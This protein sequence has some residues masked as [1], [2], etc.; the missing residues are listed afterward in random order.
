VLWKTEKL[1]I[2][3]KKKLSTEPAQEPEM[4]LLGTHLKEMES[5][6]SKVPYTPVTI[7]TLFT[8]AELGNRPR[9]CQRMNGL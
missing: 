3:L 7:K 2:E 9:P 8:T 5:A 4:P 6:H 1:S